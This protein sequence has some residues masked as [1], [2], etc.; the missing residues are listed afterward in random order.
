VPTVTPFDVSALVGGPDGLSALSSRGARSD[1]LHLTTIRDYIDTRF[2]YTKKRQG[3]N[4]AWTEDEGWW[5]AAGGFAFEDALEEA[6]SRAIAESAGSTLGL[7]RHF[8]V[9]RDGIVGSPDGY[10]PASAELVEFKLTFK[11]YRTSPPQDNWRFKYQ[12]MSY[13][14][15]ARTV[16]PVEA[17]NLVAF[18]ICGDWSPPRPMPPVGLRFTWTDRELEE[19]W[20]MTLSARDAMVREGLVP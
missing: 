15:M 6:M 9:G 3:G 10:D 2:N 13:M 7:L 12:M 1:G 11:S 20:R 14:H 8:E 19:S 4:G 5:A 16:M 18:F 17:V